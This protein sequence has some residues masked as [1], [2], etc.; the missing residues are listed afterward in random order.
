MGAGRDDAAAR[1]AVLGAY[2]LDSEPQDAAT[3]VSAHG[4]RRRV[5]PAFCGDRCARMGQR[6][7][8]FL[9]SAMGDDALYRR[10]RGGCRA[11]S[12]PLGKQRA[13]DVLLLRTGTRG[14]ARVRPRR[15]ARATTVRAAAASRDRR[16]GDGG[17]YLPRLE[18]VKASALLAALGVFGAVLVVR[19]LGVRRGLVYAVLGASLRECRSPCT[20]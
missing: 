16:D 18:R 10:R 4:D 3:R 5:G 1:S 8:V 2:D 11:R 12:S 7:R 13:D 17:R 15:A 9:R 14:T 19:A 6:R 20:P